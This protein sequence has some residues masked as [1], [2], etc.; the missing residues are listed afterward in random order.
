MTEV[1]LCQVCSKEEASETCSE[2][3][4]PLCEFCVRE[5]IISDPSLA[6]HIKGVT[7]SPVRS[8]ETRRKVCESCLDEVED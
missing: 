7:V 5:V 4:I 2:C 3:G 1:T 6:Y 8:G